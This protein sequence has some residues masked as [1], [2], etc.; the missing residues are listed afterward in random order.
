VIRAYREKYSTS[1]QLNTSSHGI[2]V[3]KYRALSIIWKKRG[4]A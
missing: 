3:Q 4:G 2:F 1:S